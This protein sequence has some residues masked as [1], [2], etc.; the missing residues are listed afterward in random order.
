M[1]VVL[2]PIFMA[3][4]KIIFCYIFVAV[5]PLNLDFHFSKKLIL[6]VSIK[7]FKIDEKCFL[8][9]AKISLRS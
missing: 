7:A 5:A 4:T 8:F 1:L 6:F 2:L 3:D 9:H